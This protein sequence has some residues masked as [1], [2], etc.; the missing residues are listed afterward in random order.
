MEKAVKLVVDEHT[1]GMDL[2]GASFNANGS[3]DLDDTISFQFGDYDITLYNLYPKSDF[4]EN[5]NSIIML[6]EKD[7]IKT[8]LTGD[9]NVNDQIEQKF[10]GIITDQKCEMDIW[11]L[12]NGLMAIG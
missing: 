8:L 9:I 4:T 6:V 3:G 10:A 12:M 5:A 2:L 11:Q 1:G 7:G